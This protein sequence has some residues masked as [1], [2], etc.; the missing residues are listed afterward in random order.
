MLTPETRWTRLS[1]PEQMTALTVL[2]PMVWQ[3]QRYGSDEDYKR[4]QD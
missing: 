4:Q 2:F 1:P 3:A